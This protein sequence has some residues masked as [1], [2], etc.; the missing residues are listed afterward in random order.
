MIDL[1]EVLLIRDPQFLVDV[2]PSI[3]NVF[4][5]IEQFYNFS[6]P[7]MQGHRFAFD[8]ALSK[9]LSSELLVRRS[10]DAEE[11]AKGFWGNSKGEYRHTI[12]QERLASAVRSYMPSEF[13]D[14]PMLLVIDQEITPPRDWR[15]IIWDM[16]SSGSVISTAPLDPRY[17]RDRTPQRIGAIKHRVR[18]AALN[19]TGSL[20]G[21]KRCSNDCCFLYD[22][23]ESTDVLD[24]M[25][26]LGP[27]H[28]W[29]DLAGYGYSPRP[30][31]PERLQSISLVR[32][33]KEESLELSHPES[34][35]NTYE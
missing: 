7:R 3:W 1:L 24:S 30:R 26:I 20:L 18:V 34:E 19:I 17:W 4:K 8:P 29:S 5:E 13:R 33:G 32:T 11:L 21:L 2:G 14:M 31:H 15:Y 28:G 27:E 6:Q 12:D 22:N 16:A 25:L 23:V 35:W 9:P 10:S